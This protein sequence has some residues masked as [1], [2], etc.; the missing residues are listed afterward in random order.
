[1]MSQTD[2]GDDILLFL[3]FGKYFTIKQLESFCY[4]HLYTPV[5]FFELE[6]TIKIHNMFESWN[7]EEGILHGSWDCGT[8]LT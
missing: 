8:S 5:G 1:M 6:N 3:F 7:P 4:Y 2:P